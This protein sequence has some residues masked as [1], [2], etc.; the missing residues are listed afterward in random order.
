M[1]IKFIVCLVG[2]NGLKFLA[3]QPMEIPYF[4]DYVSAENFIRSLKPKGQWY[5]IEKIFIN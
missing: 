5:Q 1:K 3:N 2:E 4:D